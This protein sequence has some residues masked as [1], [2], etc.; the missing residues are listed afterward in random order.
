M[1]IV[2]RRK[3]GR[4]GEKQVCW[5]TL[6]S[7]E[8]GQQRLMLDRFAGPKRG[9]VVGLPSGWNI[10]TLRQDLG[11]VGKECVSHRGLASEHGL[12]FPVGLKPPPPPLVTAGTGRRPGSQPLR[13]GQECAASVTARPCSSATA[14]AG[15]RDTAS[16]V[17]PRPGEAGPTS[18]HG[19]RGGGWGGGRW[20]KAWDG[21]AQSRGRAVGAQRG[22][23]AWKAELEGERNERQEE[24]KGRPDPESGGEGAETKG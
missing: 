23:G 4:W 9:Q 8:Q 1:G 17:S 20:T 2:G 11:R 24:G 12:F 10:P 18:V 16:A 6:P 19:A 21:G 22:S 3:A 7:Q 13:P 5:K 14:G 15:C